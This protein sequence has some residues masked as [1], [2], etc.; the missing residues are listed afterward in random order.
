VQRGRHR[1]LPPQW[2]PRRAGEL[3]WKV[4]TPSAERDEPLIKSS[5]GKES[6]KDTPT[7]GTS[8]EKTEQVIGK[9]ERGDLLI[10]GFWARGTDC[11]LDA[12][13]TDADAKSHCKRTPVKVPE[14]QEKEKKHLEARLASKD[15]N[16]SP[17]FSA[18][19]MGC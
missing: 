5:R 6:E 9:E 13:V 8:Q 19:Q 10:D 4:F 12:R 2:D 14:S 3:R 1:D 17:N 11:M 16:T 7:K 18:Q 15:V